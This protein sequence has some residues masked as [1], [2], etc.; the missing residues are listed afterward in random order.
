[1]HSKCVAQAQ[2]G[3]IGYRTAQLVC[4]LRMLE[5]C[6]WRNLSKHYSVAKFPAFCSNGP[7]LKQEFPLVMER[8][9]PSRTKHVDL[10]GTSPPFVMP[11]LGREISHPSHFS[12][13]FLSRS[14]SLH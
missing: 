6:Y 14:S 8:S 12:P 3:A 11:S 2:R 13:K 7:L 5:G 9:S 10:E 4:E 1:M